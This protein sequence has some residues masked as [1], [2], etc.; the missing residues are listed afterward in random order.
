L[1]WFFLPTLIL[2]TLFW[3]KKPHVW[4]TAKNIEPVTVYVTIQN[5]EFLEN[6]KE[7]LRDGVIVEYDLREP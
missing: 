1:A 4:F 6:F 7:M 2:F 5:R 3:P